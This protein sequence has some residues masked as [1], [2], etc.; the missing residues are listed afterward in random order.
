MADR[1]RRRISSPHVPEPPAGTFSRAIQ[2]GDQLFVAG[3]TA[4]SPSGVEG[5]SS[6]YDQTRS[7]FTKIR[8]LVEA[9]GGTM[10]DI[11]KMTGF[12]RPR[13]SWKP[14]RWRPPGSSSKS[15]WR[16]SAR[17]EPPPRRVR[18]GLRPRRNRGDGRPRGDGE[19]PSPAA[20]AS[21]GGGRSPIECAEGRVEAPNAFEAGGERD[22]THR[23]RAV[24]E[25]SLGALKSAGGG[26]SRRRG[27]GMADE[28][29]AEMS[30]RHPERPGQIDDRLA[31][32]QE[33]AVDELEG[34]RDAR[35][36]AA[37]RGRARCGLG[38]AAKAWT[39]ARLLRGSRRRKEHHVR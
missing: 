9:A 11:V 6:M 37:P 33:S 30:G 24:V 29:A 7:V 36:G 28:E 1:K 14:R 10:N 12:R 8:H 4:N 39:E 31:V 18:A 22:R 32:V 38:P 23:H 34:A 20:R 26:D 13:R 2:V 19:R 15:R 16:S 17:A 27:A 25:Q 21:H 35:G 3:M 5:G